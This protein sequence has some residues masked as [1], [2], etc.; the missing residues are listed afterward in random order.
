[1][2]D[3]SLSTDLAESSADFQRSHFV[4]CAIVCVKSCT[5]RDKDQTDDFDASATDR[6][7]SLSLRIGPVWRRGLS[8][9]E[10]P[11][12]FGTAQVKGSPSSADPSA[13]G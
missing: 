6:W 7:P 5:F 13:D 2:Y 9:D 4:V 10:S 1:M 8:V 12:V 11:S 3:S